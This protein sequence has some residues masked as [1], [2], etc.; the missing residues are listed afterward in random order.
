MQKVHLN[1]CRGC[2]AL[3]PDIEGPVHDYMDSSPACWAAFGQVLAREYSSASLKSVHRL[4]VDSYAIQHPGAASRQA[5]QSV[6]VHL[7]RLCLF[8]EQGLSAEDANSAMLLIG[9][10]K[11]KMHHLTRPESLGDVTVVNVL[12]ASGET[13][14]REVVVRWANSAWSAWKEHHSVVRQ[15]VDASR[16]S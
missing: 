10:T 1:A 15:W 9:K 16:T 14:H 7:A 5:V 3:L 12:E 6:G 8:L 13:A 2:G 4:S 11:S